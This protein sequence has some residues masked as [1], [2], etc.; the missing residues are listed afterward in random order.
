MNIRGM[1]GYYSG[2][3]FKADGCL[4]FGRNPQDCNILYPDQVKGISRKH[5]KIDVAGGGLMLTDLGS[6]YGTF[7]NGMKLSPHSAVPIKEGDTFWLGNK[8]N[9]FTISTSPGFKNGGFT[10]PIQNGNGVNKKMLIKVAL[11]AV[12]LL[13]FVGLIIYNDLNTK[14]LIKQQQEAHQ[15]QLEQM[16][17]AMEERQRMDMELVEHYETEAERE[18]NKT[19]GQRFG[20]GVGGLLDGLK[21]YIPLFK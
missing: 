1:S 5:C 13:I 20:E 3:E 8:E 19:P 21:D 12:T 9:S 16:Q 7:L 15:Q 2:K 14:Q 10:T 6:S 11:V 4:Y 17:E 18:Q